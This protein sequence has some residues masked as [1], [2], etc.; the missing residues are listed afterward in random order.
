MSKSIIKLTADGKL[1][2]LEW[3]DQY[4]HIIKLIGEKCEI[5][6]HVRPRR[7]YSV[8]K[9]KDTPD[10]KYP[11]R[12]ISML[13]DEEANYHDLPINPIASW[14]YEYDRHGNVIRGNVLF[15][16]EMWTIDG[17]SFCALDDFAG[18]ALLENL[19]KAISIFKELDKDCAFFKKEDSNV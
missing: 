10:R 19:S 12:C 8:F 17:L 16:G 3:P 11:G 14:L 9:C 6:E 4:E 2:I 13:M 1:S 5:Y 18:L 15:V 7:L